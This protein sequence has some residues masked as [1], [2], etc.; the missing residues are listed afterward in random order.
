MALQK[1]LFRAKD[2]MMDFIEGGTH[3]PDDVIEEAYRI[4]HRIGILEIVS[5]KVKV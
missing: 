1:H 3:L 4:M 2:E 5:R